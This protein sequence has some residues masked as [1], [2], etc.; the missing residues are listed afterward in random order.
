MK[1]STRVYFVTKE[2]LLYKVKR[3]EGGYRSWSKVSLLPSGSDTR[4]IEHGTYWIVVSPSIRCFSGG[5]RVFTE[6]AAAW[7][8]EG[9]SG[10][11]VVVLAIPVLVACHEHG[12]AARGLDDGTALFHDGE[13]CDSEKGFSYLETNVQHN[14]DLTKPC[15]TQSTR[16]G[17]S[18]A[19]YTSA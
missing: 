15:T 18:H 19:S 9:S 3:Q 12:G 6:I 8:T 14:R 4:C 17:Y 13:A 16:C 2:P 10:G 7:G 11:V 5:R 1:L